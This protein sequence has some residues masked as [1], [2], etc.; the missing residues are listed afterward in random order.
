[1]TPI[2]KAL[3]EVSDLRDFFRRILKLSAATGAK[4]DGHDK[5]AQPAIDPAAP[6]G[7]SGAQRS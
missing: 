3:R 4:R 1:M 6:A 2:E 5:S 7:R